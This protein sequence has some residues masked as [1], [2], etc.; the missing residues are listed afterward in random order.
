MKDAIKDMRKGITK[1][2]LQKFKDW[3]AKHGKAI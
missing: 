2:E 3:A 1:E